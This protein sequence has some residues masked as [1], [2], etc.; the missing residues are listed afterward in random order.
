[1]ADKHYAS[2]SL[3]LDS[4]LADT[5]AIAVGPFEAGTIIA[6]TASPGSSRT[7][8][9]YVADSEDGTYRILYDSDGST[10]I[11][12]INFTKNEAQKIPAAALDGVMWLKLVPA[13]EDVAGVKITF[14]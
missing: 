1:M 4:T 12:I 8:S 7:I 9:C 11:Q 3:D 10:A 5:P 14:N 13:S 6:P 2:I